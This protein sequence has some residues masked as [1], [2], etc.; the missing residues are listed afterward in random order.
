MS[1]E[2]RLLEGSPRPR[3]IRGPGGRVVGPAGI[4]PGLRQAPTPGS[5]PGGRAAIPRDGKDPLSSHTNC[6]TGHRHTLEGHNAG[7]RHHKD[8]LV[9]SR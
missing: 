7:G 1:I 4:A 8:R 3:L 5:P 2:G 6:F 9:A